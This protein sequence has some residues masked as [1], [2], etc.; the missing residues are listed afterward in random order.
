MDVNVWKRWVVRWEFM[1]PLFGSV[2]GDPEMVKAWLDARKPKARPPGGR[3]IEEVQEEV[4][5]TL[6]EGSTDG[7]EERS[8]LV[9]QRYGGNLVIRT[10]T[11]RA[12]LKDC[13]RV[14]SAQHI[15]KLKG[16]R[17]F[18]TKVI[19]GLYTDPAKPFTEIARL[20][21][22]LVKSHDGELDRAVHTFRGSALKRLQYVEPPS[23]IEFVLQTLG[24]SIKLSDLETLLTYGGVHGYGGERSRDGGKYFYTISE[25]KRND[26]QAKKRGRAAEAAPD[27]R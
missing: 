2:P 26:V 9:F 5:S 20:D 23:V 14:I 18:S 16:E 13:A 11:I 10:E 12:H 15:G 24:D 17:A 27:G 3:S 21:G 19:N 25:E 4:L 8:L 22:S 7:A 6:A 1:S